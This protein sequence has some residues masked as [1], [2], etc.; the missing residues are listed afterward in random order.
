M[1]NEVKFDKNGLIPCIVQEEGS[2]DV[3]MLAY[4]SKESLEYTIKNKLG[5][6]YSRS[7]KQ[8]WIKGET[9]GHYQH[10]KEIYL[11]CDGDTIL[12]V[13]KQDGVACHTGSHSCFFRRFDL[14]ETD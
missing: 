6:Y 3:L 2:K 4:M 11:D 12:L 1:I 13:V 7:R 8:L 10:V 14:D 5:C 9:S